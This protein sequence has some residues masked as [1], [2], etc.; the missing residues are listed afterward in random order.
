MSV[1]ASFVSLAMVSYNK[2]TSTGKSTITQAY[3]FVLVII[4]CILSITGLDISLLLLAY[5]DYIPFVVPSHRSLF[6]SFISEWLHP[7][8][9]NCIS[10]CVIMIR[11]CH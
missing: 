1:C 5:R 4:I 3:C 11:C 7:S 10:R 8:H 2:A 6:V 9:D